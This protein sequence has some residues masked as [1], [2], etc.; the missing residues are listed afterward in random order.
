MSS[1][2]KKLR[3]FSRGPVTPENPEIHP[4]NSVFF[5][6]IKIFAKMFFK[7][8]NEEKLKLLKIWWW[9]KIIQKYT[10]PYSFYNNSLERT[11]LVERSR[12][13]ADLQR[14][15]SDVI[16]RAFYESDFFI[17][18]RYIVF[19]KHIS[20]TQPRFDVPRFDCSLYQYI[21]I[22]STIPMS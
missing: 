2:L 1:G 11:V 14:F 5:I 13:Q 18:I 7:Y 20:S 8:L 12:K 10:W 21:I 6:K 22:L 17:H 9:Y 19:D 16:L 15:Q 3:I 4:E